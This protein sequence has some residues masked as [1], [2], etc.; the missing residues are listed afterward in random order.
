MDHSWAWTRRPDVLMLI[1]YKLHFMT[2]FKP[3][4]RGC[5]DARTSTQALHAATT[6][7]TLKS[8][9]W[10]VIPVHPGLQAFP[11]EFDMQDTSGSRVSQRQAGMD[12]CHLSMQHQTS[13]GLK[14]HGLKDSCHSQQ[15]PCCAEQSSQPPACPFCFAAGCRAADPEP[16]AVPWV[17][18]TDRDGVAAH[19]VST[20][21]SRCYRSS[22][23]GD[24]L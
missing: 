16:S 2:L 21:L 1:A 11:Q 17:D 4:L 7:L 5:E 10:T 24:K 14:L 3:H 15:Q 6:G 23:R 20:S 19:E 18:L 9:P 22:H 12:V 8:R 13:P